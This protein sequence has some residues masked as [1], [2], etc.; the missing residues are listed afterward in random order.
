MSGHRKK[1]QNLTKMPII[2]DTVAQN[3]IKSS[4]LDN[5]HR[6]LSNDLYFVYFRGGPNFAIVFGNDVIMTSFVIVEFSNQHI[7]QNII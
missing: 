2:F 7:L 3:S 6:F 4:F 5:S 1:S